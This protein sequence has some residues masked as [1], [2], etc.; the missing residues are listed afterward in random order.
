[1]NWKMRKKNERKNIF[2]TVAKTFLYV[3]RQILVYPVEKKITTVINIEKM[4]S[5][6]PS[7]LAASCCL[8]NLSNNHYK[9]I[10]TF[11]RI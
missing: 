7:Q 3:Y 5:H 4:S 10:K 2:I 8:L 9:S 6:F 1:M 11:S